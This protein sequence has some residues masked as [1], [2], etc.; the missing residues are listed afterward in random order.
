MTRQIGDE[1]LIRLGNMVHAPFVTHSLS[2]LH[3]T[4]GEGMHMI[5][6]F[7]RG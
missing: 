6:G 1:K 5:N 4:Q 3:V 2:F 7:L